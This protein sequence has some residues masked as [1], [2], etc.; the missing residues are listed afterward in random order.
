MKWFRILIGMILAVMLTGAA[1]QTSNSI[2]II[3]QAVA[4]DMLDVAK[5][6]AA[7]P[8]GFAL[9][10]HPPYQFVAYYDKHRRL[11][12]AQRKLDQRKWK[13]TRLPDVTGWD[14]HNYIAL[15]A[16][17]D[18]YLHL[19]ADMHVAPL[20]YFRT[21]K[22][23]DASTFKRLDRMTGSNETHCTY[24]DF[25]RGTNGQMLFT[26]R[27]GGSGDGN[28]IYDC[29]DL[30][31]QTWH[32]F[33]DA[34]LTDGQGTNN[35]YFSGPTRGPDGWYHLA[36]IWRAKN[37][38]GTC[39]DLTYA[40]SRDLNHWETSTGKPLLLPIRLDNCEIIDPV[41]QH[42]GIINGN[43]KIGFD[44]QGRVCISYHKD[45]TNGY[46][47]PFV[48]RLENGHW[49]LHQVA[50]WPVHCTFSGIGTLPREIRLGP[51]QALPD[52]RLTMTFEHFKFGQGTWVLDP[53]TLRATGQ[54]IQEGTPPNLNQVTGTFPG[55][56]VHWEGDGGSNDVAGLEYKLRWESLEPNHDRPRLG[57]LPKPSMLQVVSIRVTDTAS[58]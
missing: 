55:L 31:T 47:Q 11:T 37:D 8:V 36:W 29:Y 56:V 57:A 10:T 41:P 48:V 25:M 9:L 1:A 12:V 16:D 30:K 6:S 39:H 46:T 50:D 40:R 20:K 34:P 13:L 51:V 58:K 2:P 24:P 5:V 27:D 23:W 17:A 14:S 26:Y 22:P 45:D 4:V 18:G 42:S 52:G 53:Q 19:S 44:V 32:S 33:L 35:A 15:A 28:Q 21:T 38:A 7:Y 3:R 43:T 49:V 54:V